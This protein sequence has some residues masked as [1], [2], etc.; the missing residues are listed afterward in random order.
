MILSFEILCVLMS[1]CT[2]SYKKQFFEYRR[3]MF[4]EFEIWLCDLYLS[5]RGLLFP[6]KS[7]VEIVVC[8][9][10]SKYGEKYEENVC[11]FTW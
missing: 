3:F 11:N 1:V 8:V 4:G 6:P 5:R 9:Y 7:N 10:M 2:I